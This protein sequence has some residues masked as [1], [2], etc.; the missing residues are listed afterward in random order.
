[1]RG[2]AS[3]YRHKGFF[4]RA[5]FDEAG[6][7]A[8]SAGAGALLVI[9]DRLAKLLECGC[10]VLMPADARRVLGEGLA[11]G[12]S[13][14]NEAQLE[15]GN[16]EPVDYLALGP[17]FGTATKENPDPMVGLEELARLAKRAARPLVAIGGITRANAPRVLEAGA[18]WVAVIADLLPEEGGVAAVEARV[19]EWLAVLRE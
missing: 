17:I 19:R 13:T 3:C 14:H 16:R 4:S 7:V 2:C 5:R 10:H 15:G 18:A 12:Y 11:L 9:D 8:D 1:M 6:R